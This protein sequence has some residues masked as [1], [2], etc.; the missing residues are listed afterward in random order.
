MHFNTLSIP[1]P[2]MDLDIRTDLMPSVEV[3]SIDVPPLF[4]ENFDY[5]TFTDFTSGIITS[6]LLSSKIYLKICDGYGSRR[7]SK[8]WTH[9]QFDADRLDTDRSTP[10]DIYTSSDRY[11]S[12]IFD[13]EDSISSIGSESDSESEEEDFEDEARASLER[14]LE[15]GH[16]IED[17]ALELKTLRMASNVSLEEVREVVVEV[18]M[19]KSTELKEV[20]AIMTRW[21]GLIALVSEDEA[22]AIC[23]IQ[24]SRKQMRRKQMSG[25]I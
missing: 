3:C 11:T 22:D 6:D 4:T 2:D 20:L 12:D 17:A 10:S 7:L 9:S 24:V 19:S 23:Q 18:L 14:A 15:E 1:L 5:Q 16:S 13:S 21:A 8:R 25:S